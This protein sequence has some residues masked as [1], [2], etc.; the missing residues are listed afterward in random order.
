MYLQNLKWI[1]NVIKNLKDQWKEEET[2][3]NGECYSQFSDL[4]LK[5]LEKLIK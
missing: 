2:E 4:T 1:I 5:I 3:A